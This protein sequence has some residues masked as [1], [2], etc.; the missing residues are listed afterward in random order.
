MGQI[1]RVL[2]FNLALFLATGIGTVR[3]D[4]LKTV[5]PG[6]SLGPVISGLD[7]PLVGGKTVASIGPLLLYEGE[8]VYLRGGILGVR[9]WGTQKL[10]L[11]AILEG[12]IE[13]PPRKDN[14][15]L[16]DMSARDA[17]LGAGLR[18]Q[19]IHDW[20]TIV[21]KIQGDISDAGGGHRATLA[22]YGPM[23][24]GAITFIPFVG[25]NYRSSDVV[26]YYFGVKP[27]EVT[28]ERPAYTGRSSITSY[29][30]FELTYPLTE[31]WLL[32][33]GLQSEFYDKPITDSPIV[34]KDVRTSGLISAVY[35]FR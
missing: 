25:L 22:Y 15:R 7:D 16:K 17:S 23:Y 28:A 3:A 14:D 35:R 10:E 9:F 21:A 31:Q 12:N 5:L 4:E 30:G 19:S 2:L 26:D 18:L 33:A 20:G 11:S 32:L 6:W 1:T 34:D 29:A 27:S 13:G 24:R 8:R